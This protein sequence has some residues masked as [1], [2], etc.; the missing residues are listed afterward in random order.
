[1]RQLSAIE[2]D[3]TV[4]HCAKRS[5]EFAQRREG[6]FASGPAVPRLV[7][8]QDC[9]NTAPREVAAHARSLLLNTAATRGTMEPAR[10]C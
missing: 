8:H 4:R 2:V 9:A 10:D 1:M 6:W 3:P 7:V 5:M